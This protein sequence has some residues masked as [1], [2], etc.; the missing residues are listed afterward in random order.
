MKR[1]VV[2]LPPKGWRPPRFTKAEKQF[3]RER[4]GNRCDETGVLFGPR[5]KIDYD[6]RPPIHER[7]W[8][9]KA[10]D[11]I[12]PGKSL[13]HARAILRDWHR[14]ISGKDYSRMKKTDRIRESEAEHQRRMANKCGDARKKTGSIKSRG[15]Q[16]GRKLQWKHRKK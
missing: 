15:F 4:Q 12:P 9:E 8:D 11:T 16:K 7:E 2:K 13:D 1:E 10:Q 14:V 5:A 3:L 6:H